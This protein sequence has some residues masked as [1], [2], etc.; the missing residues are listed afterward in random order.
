MTSSFVDLDRIH[1]G[2]QLNFEETF[3]E[4][5]V[6]LNLCFMIYTNGL[7]CFTGFEALILFSYQKILQRFFPPYLMFFLL[8][9]EIPHPTCHLNALFQ[10]YGG[11]K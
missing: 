2:I 8:A 4:D 7:S 10:G 9:S 5:P 3:Q 6:F 11:K 1:N